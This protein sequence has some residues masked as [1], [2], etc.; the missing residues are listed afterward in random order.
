VSKKLTQEA[1]GALIKAQVHA[2]SVLLAEAAEYC[3]CHHQS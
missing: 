2:W 1:T 3:L